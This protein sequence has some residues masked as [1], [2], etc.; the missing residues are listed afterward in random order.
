MTITTALNMV[1]TMSDNAKMA[2]ISALATFIERNYTNNKY[3]RFKKVFEKMI[4]F[5][6]DCD[7]AAR[8]YKIIDNETYTEAI[9]NIIKMNNIFANKAFNTIVEYYKTH[10]EYV[11]LDILTGEKA[12]YDLSWSISETDGTITLNFF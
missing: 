11:L 10:D 1:N 6:W 5:C 8:D 9:K 2:F 12:T 7:R 3:V 4:V